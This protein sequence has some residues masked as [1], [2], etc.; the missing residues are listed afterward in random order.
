MLQIKAFNK[1]YLLPINDEQM[2]LHRLRELNLDIRC[3]QVQRV[4]LSLLKEV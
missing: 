4:R 3:Q 2:A 1:P